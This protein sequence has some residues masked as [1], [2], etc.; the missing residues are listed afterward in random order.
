M[1]ARLMRTSWNAVNAKF[2]E[3]LFRVARVD[4]AKRKAGL[5]QEGGDKERPA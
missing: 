2:V 1:Y 4:R 5:L 3:T